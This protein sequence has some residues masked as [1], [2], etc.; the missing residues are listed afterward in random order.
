[1]SPERIEIHEIYKAES[2]E[3]LIFADLDRLFHSMDGTLG[4][5]CL[6]DALSVEDI[7]DLSDRDHI[8][9]VVL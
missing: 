2:L 4:T 8:V 7:P 5:E 3:I 9:S 1:M 6:R